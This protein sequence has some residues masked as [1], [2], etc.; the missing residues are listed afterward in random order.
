MCWDR[1]QRWRD[2]GEVVVLSTQVL[3]YDKGD[4]AITPHRYSYQCSC[5]L[6]NQNKGEIVLVERYILFHVV[7]YN[8]DP[9][10]TACGVYAYKPL[11]I[12]HACMLVEF[13]TIAVTSLT[14]IVYKETWRYTFLRV[15]MGVHMYQYV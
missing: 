12:M 7:I 13:V 1:T 15:A 8:I 10:E 4:E 9:Q 2:N 5:S 11:T 6:W 3:P 14:C